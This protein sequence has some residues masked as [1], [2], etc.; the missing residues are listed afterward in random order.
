MKILKPVPIG[1][2]QLVAASIPETDHP[3]WK[4]NVT[5]ARG[6]FVISPAS[7]TVYRSLQDGNLGHDPDLEQL[8]LADP[9]IDDPDPVQWQVIGATNRWR[10]F[11][12]KPSARATAAEAITV[13]LAPGVAIAGVAG[14]EISAAK[15]RVTM[16]N[17]GAEIYAR[18]IAM[19]DETVVGDWSGYFFEPITEL[20][21]FVLTD[22]PPYA[23]ATL[24]IEALRPGGTV[25]IGQLVCGP[26]WPVGR[27][28]I[29]GSGFQGVDFSYVAQDE[30]GDLTTVRRAATRLSSFEVWVE[31]ARLLGLDARLRTL[32]GGTA[33]VWIG[34]DDPRKA[35]MNYGFYRGYRSAY[36]TD[37]WSLL[38]IDVQGIV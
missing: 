28:A 26:L 31:N 16:T 13:E 25:S 8:A 7:H 1:E 30:F 2:A 32:R 21:E 5:Y 33:A 10:L 29:K 15:V 36:Q 18:E 9:L 38:Q 14:F 23:N 6:A 17:A 27:T 20:S 37:A 34:D 19:Q 22:M 11:D 35:A 12:G 3:V 24:R 4:A